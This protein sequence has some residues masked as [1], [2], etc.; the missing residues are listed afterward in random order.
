MSR[1]TAVSKTVRVSESETIDSSNL[2]LTL[3]SHDGVTSHVSEH[4]RHTHTPGHTDRLTAL[5]NRE[6]LTT[7][8]GLVS[9]VCTRLTLIVTFA[10]DNYCR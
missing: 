10:R 8:H 2:S 9:H 4:T 6:T 1:V 7:L 5:V 3:T